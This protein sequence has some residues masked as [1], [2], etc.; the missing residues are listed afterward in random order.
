MSDPNRLPPFTDRRRAFPGVIPI[1]PAIK[2]L[3]ERLAAEHGDDPGD[4]LADL[5]S[6]MAD[7]IEGA[8]FHPREIELG[9]APTP[10]SDQPADEPEPPAAP[11]PQHGPQTAPR[12][13]PAGP[14]P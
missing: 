3:A 5:L 10:W 8:I 6:E 13:P 1:P 11:E 14:A 12:V 4:V 2:K 7:G 9:F